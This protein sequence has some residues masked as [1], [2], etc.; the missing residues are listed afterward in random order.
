MVEHRCSIG[1]RGGFFERLRTGTYFAHIL[2]HIA[3]ELQTL[4]GT[5]VGYGRA[6][7]TSEE[8]VYQGCL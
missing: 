4:A 1:E 3:L 5:D 8:G 2:E 7:E 6:R